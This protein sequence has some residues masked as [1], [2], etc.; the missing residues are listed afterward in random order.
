VRCKLVRERTHVSGT[1]SRFASSVESITS[2]SRIAITVR[3]LAGTWSPNVSTGPSFVAAPILSEFIGRAGSWSVYDLA[4]AGELDIAAPN[5]KRV[6]VRL[7][8]SA[9]CK[10][11][12]KLGQTRSLG[13]AHLTE[14]SHRLSFLLLGFELE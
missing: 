1:L 4:L 8:S 11:L 6:A 2:F 14:I 10:P 3:C 5:R 13:A 9:P 12:L 7:A